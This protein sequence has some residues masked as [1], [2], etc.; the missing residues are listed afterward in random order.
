SLS[1]LKA[2]RS[3]KKNLTPSVLH[4][5]IRSGSLPSTVLHRYLYFWLVPRERTLSR[6][7]VNPHDYNGTTNASILA[8]E[9]SIDLN[10]EQTALDPQTRVTNAKPACIDKR[11]SLLNLRKDRKIINQ[12]SISNSLQSPLLRLPPEVRNQIFSHVLGSCDIDI[13]TKHVEYF[14]ETKQWPHRIWHVAR[15]LDSERDLEY[16]ISSRSRKP[17]FQ[18]PLVCRQI[19][20]ETKLLHYA[21]NRFHFAGSARNVVGKRANSWYNPTDYWIEQ[22]TKAQIEAV[23]MI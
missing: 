12:I 8:K 11:T 13:H 5:F 2:T 7:N 19:Y 15:P 10:F 16:A 9:Q 14:P 3:R 4:I 6:T 1:S 17:D 18:L 23:T 20:H 22:H 21:L